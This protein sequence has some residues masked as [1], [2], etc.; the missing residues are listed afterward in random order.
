MENHREVAANKE[1]LLRAASIFGPEHFDEYLQLYAE[2]AQLHFLP[3]ELPQGRAGAR[4][5]YRSIFDAFH[6]LRLTIDDMIGERDQIGLRFTLVGTQVA[7]FRGFPPP[8]GGAPIRVTGVTIFRFANG[9]CIERWSE[10]NLVTA[11][12]QQASA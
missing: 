4:L 5:F 1:T 7:T 2:D 9:Q 6:D 10:T 3:P 8:P 12:Q 11:L